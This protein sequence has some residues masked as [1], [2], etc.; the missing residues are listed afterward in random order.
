MDYLRELETFVAIAD[1]K[2]LIGAARQQRLSAPAV[3]RALTSL[4]ARLG[5]RLV[6]RTTRSL[7]LTE[8]GERFLSEVRP[9]LSALEAA[10]ASASGRQLRA[11][12]LLSVT[13]PELFGD[14]HVAPLLFE[15]LEQHPRVTTR[16]LFSNRVVHLIEEGFDVAVRIASLPDST[17]T[18]MLLGAMRVVLV[19]SPAY[20]ERRGT[21]LSPK[22]LGGHH[23]IGLSIE[24][25]G[26]TSWDFDGRQRR[27][28]AVE[29][30][31]VVNSNAVKVAAAV[32]GL[33]VARAL[34]YQVADEVRDGR[35]RV[36]LAPHEPAPVPV[37]L[38]YPEGRAATAKV[39]RFLDLAS[40]RLRAL[41]VLQ[42]GGLEGETQP[43]CR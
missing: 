42:G 43:G 16:A 18:A 35:L 29:E 13:A 19:A 20:L 26:H 8:A 40:E 27:S 7:A 17:L 12:G 41:P 28:V 24:G 39:R 10:E 25:Q 1:A 6:L 34:A 31:L 4:E 23:A 38:V 36:L 2:S 5:V 33:G 11:E 9:L 22:D 32:A 21:P 15:F 37:Y 3:T 14:R 30:R